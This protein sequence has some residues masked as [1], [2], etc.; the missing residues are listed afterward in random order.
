MF[1]KHFEA[2]KKRILEKSPAIKGVEWYNQQY[3]KG[4]NSPG[5]KAFPE[6]CVFVEFRPWNPDTY[7]GGA[8]AGELEVVIHL[9]SDYL[10][11]PHRQRHAEFLMQVDKALRG[12]RAVLSYVEVTTKDRPLFNSLMRTSARADHGHDRQL[13]SL[14]DYVCMAYDY[15]AVKELVSRPT[16]PKIISK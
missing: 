2:I 11:E 4:G 8:Q 6:P 7:P 14:M 10:S 5:K 13:V 16:E 12:F 15:A 3:L 1:L 9:V